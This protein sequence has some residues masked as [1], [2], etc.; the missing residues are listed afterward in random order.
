MSTYQQKCAGQLCGQFKSN[1]N[2]QIWH[3]LAIGKGC[4]SYFVSSYQDKNNEMTVFTEKCCF[5][6]PTGNNK[7]CYSYFVSSYQDKNNFIG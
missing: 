5:C 1:Q 6:P 7:V 2:R 4:Y 3:R